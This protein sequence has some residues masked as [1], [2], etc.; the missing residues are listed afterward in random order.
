MYN[1]RIGG[2][3][4]GTEFVNVKKKIVCVKESKFLRGKSRFCIL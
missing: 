3:V 4:Y 2:M 1:K